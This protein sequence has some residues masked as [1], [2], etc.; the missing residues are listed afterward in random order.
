ML[1]ISYRNLKINDLSHCWDKREETNLEAESDRCFC[2]NRF[3]KNK[4]KLSR[5]DTTNITFPEHTHHRLKLTWLSHSYGSNSIHHFQLFWRACQSSSMNYYHEFCNMK[6]NRKLFQVIDKSTWRQGYRFQLPT[7]SWHFNPIYI[8]W[9]QVNDGH[10]I[11]VWCSNYVK[12]QRVWYRPLNHL[13]NKRNYMIWN[14]FSH[15]A[16]KWDHVLTKMCLFTCEHNLL[17]DP[18]T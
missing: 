3:S 18:H 4:V 13:Y 6:S 11:G 5:S 12:R 14:F 2:D 1:N 17:Y 15:E 9:H 8:N 10:H 7:T 16:L